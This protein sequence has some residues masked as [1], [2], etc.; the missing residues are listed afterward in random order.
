MFVGLDGYRR[1]WAAVSISSRGNKLEF[2]PHIGEL[3]VRDYA[4]AMI[5]IPI[6]LP[7]SGVRAC[8]RE[9]RRLLGPNAPRLFTGA[10]R[11]LLGHV[12]REDAHCWATASGQAGV[13]CQLFCLL[14]KIKQVDAVMTADR[15]EK[16]RETHPELVFLKL[17][18]GKSLPSKKTPEGQNVRADLLRK[19]GFGELEEFLLMR[20]G[21]RAKPDDILDACACALAA[22]HAAEGIGS[23]VPGDKLEKDSRGLKMQIWY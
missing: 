10:R 22:K 21:T 17:N 4:M 11:P 20:L 5:D 3:F 18:C 14:P 2:L 19:Q 8:D 13:S 15:Q 1:G 7:T 16:T 23:C 6:G 9:G 12:T